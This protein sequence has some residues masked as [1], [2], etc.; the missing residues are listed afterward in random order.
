M[1]IVLDMLKYKLVCIFVKN[2]FLTPLPIVKSFFLFSFYLFLFPSLSAKLGL[3]PLR[4]WQATSHGRSEILSHTR[5][6]PQPCLP[7]LFVT[8]SVTSTALRQ[9]GQEGVHAEEKAESYC[10][11]WDWLNERIKSDS[12]QVGHCHCK[13]PSVERQGTKMSRVVMI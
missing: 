7:A 11:E 6:I 13:A 5:T 12:N 8:S 10:L 1:D 2:I 4:Y 3:R 9:R